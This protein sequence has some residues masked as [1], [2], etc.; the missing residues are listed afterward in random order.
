MDD[1]KSCF[2]LR[3]TIQPPSDE[4]YCTVHGKYVKIDG[5]CNEY[6]YSENN[7]FIKFKDEI[8]K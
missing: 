7:P 2:A 4:Q 6:R 8:P 5:Y 3:I 1:C